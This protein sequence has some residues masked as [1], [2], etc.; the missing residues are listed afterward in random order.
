MYIQAGYDRDQRS[1]SNVEFVGLIPGD[2]S[3]NQRGE[4]NTTTRWVSFQFDDVTLEET[5]DVNRVRVWTRR[6]DIAW[7]PESR[8]AEEAIPPRM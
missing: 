8:R 4:L 3:T 6:T 1:L 2:A 5:I 7:R